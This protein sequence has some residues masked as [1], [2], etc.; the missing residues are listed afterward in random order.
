LARLPCPCLTCLA[1][2]SWIARRGRKS[3]QLRF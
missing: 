2:L 1:R 3:S